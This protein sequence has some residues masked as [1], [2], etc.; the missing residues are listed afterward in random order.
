MKEEG[1][2]MLAILARNRWWLFVRGIAAFVFGLLAFLWPGITPL[3]LALLCGAYALVD[4]IATLM[5]VLSGPRRKGVAIWPL[6]LVGVLGT[7][8]GFSAFGWAGYIIFFEWP[9]LSVIGALIL[10]ALWAVA[11]GIFEVIAAMRLRK[12]I[13]GE[14]VLGLTGIL[15]IALGVVLVLQPAVALET[16]LWFVWVYGVVAGALYIA[17]GFRLGQYERRFRHA[18]RAA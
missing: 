1:A 13:E 15:T 6:V 7:A 5:L 4:G 12:E 10:I 14:W 16:L 8:A 11:R 17:L 3:V 2:E 9:P 18:S